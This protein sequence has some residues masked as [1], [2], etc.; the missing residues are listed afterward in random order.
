MSTPSTAPIHARVSSIFTR[1]IA[2]VL[3]ISL[4]LLIPC[5]WHEHIQ[6]G[7]LG[8]HTYNAWLA[9]LVEQGNA[10]G[11][12]LATQWQNV[13]FDL[14]LSCTCKAF[15]FAL[16]EKLAVSFC[17]QIFFWGV[18]A[19][20]RSATKRPPWLLIPLVAMMTHGYV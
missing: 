6:A 18:F 15:G 4:L 16:G 5:F 11:L 7:D 12:Y 17:V 19:L 8:S 2:L 14:L 3:F 9:Q 10:P 20:L 13:L 1:K